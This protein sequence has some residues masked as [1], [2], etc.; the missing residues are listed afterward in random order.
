MTCNRIQK[1]KTPD[2][3]ECDACKHISGLHLWCCLFG[4]WVRPPPAKQRPSP[5]ELVLPP[6]VKGQPKIIIPNGS[7]KQSSGCGGCGGKAVAGIHKAINIGKGYAALLAEKFFVLPEFSCPATAD[8]LAIC[9]S[10]KCGK[11]TRLSKSRY[12]WFIIK[13][14]RGVITNIS[15]LSILPELPKEDVGLHEF[16]MTCKCYL[17]A[18]VRVETEKCPLEKWEDKQ[19]SNGS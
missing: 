7:Q 15:D 8:R 14:F 16:C 2:L 12:L 3:I 9:Q 6:G 17:S 4:F 1:P 5:T 19:V 18:K 13:H 10:D 11:L